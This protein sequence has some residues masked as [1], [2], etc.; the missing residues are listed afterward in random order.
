LLL[1]PQ[2]TNL[3]EYSEQF[4]NAYWSKDPWA[5]VVANAAIS[6]DGYQNAD[7]LNFAAS[8][9]AV[10]KAGLTLSGAHRFTVY[11]KGEGAN[12]GKEIYLEIGGGTSINVTLSGEWQRFTALADN[13]SSVAIK[14]L[15]SAQANSVLAWGAQIEA[16]AYATSYIP[17]TSASVTRVADAASK[18]GIS[19]LI[20]Q[21][22][23]TIFVDF[24]ANGIPRIINIYNNDRSPS[25]ISTN[26]ILI[27]TNGVIEAQTFKGNG[28]FQT[29]SMF[30]A[31]YSAGQRLK[32]GFRYKSGD[33]ALY[34]NGVQKATDSSSLTFIGTKTTIELDDNNQVYGFQEA[35]Q[36]NQLLQFKTPL[37]NAQ[38]AE[39]TTL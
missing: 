37:T 1:E 3:L 26:A 27:Q 24:V 13:G 8:G 29:I 20:G 9:N 23:G 11:L 38:L 28:T 16:G 15:N 19:S 31:G 17:T 33:F 10:Y 30:A 4:D 34:V 18:T 36:Y 39:L 12:I 6:P 21:T 2:R 14:Q 22:E 32:I 7:R 35:V 25:T 5:S